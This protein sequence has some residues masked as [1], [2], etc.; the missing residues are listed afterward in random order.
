MI[1]FNFINQ[2]ENKLADLKMFFVRVVKIVFS[3]YNRGLTLIEVL[4][5][6][7]VLAVGIVAVLI[8]FPSGIKAEKSAQIVS[9][10]VGL[11]Q[12]KIE[13]MVSLP[14]SDIS[15]LTEDY[16]AIPE[17][18]FFRRTTEVFCYDPN[19]DDL[20]PDCPESG[21]KKVEVSVFWESGFGV[22]KSIKLST[23]ISKR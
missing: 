10:A 14:Y 15:S 12:A 5:A 16:G 2:T 17:F 11:A 8:M 22:E 13:E 23:L 3:Q 21:M 18:D 6:V 7:F 1:F 4:I 20:P 9:V 19:G